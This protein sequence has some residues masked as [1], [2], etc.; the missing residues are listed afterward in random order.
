MSRWRLDGTG[1]ITTL[2]ARGQA[3]DT[4]SP[5]GAE[6]LVA[7]Y[8]SVI[9][10]AAIDGGAAAP[11]TAVWDVERDVLLDPLDGFDGSWVG[12]R[13]L[14]GSFADGTVG[15]YD[16]DSG[17]GVPEIEVPPGDGVWYVPEAERTYEWIV[18]DTD[19]ERQ[20]GVIKT[21]DSSEDGD[22]GGDIAPDIPIVGYVKS[23]SATS[24]GTADRRHRL[25]ARCRQ[26]PQWRIVPHHRVR[27][28]DA[29]W[30]SVSP[31]WGRGPLRSA[32]T[33]RCSAAT[34]CTITEYDL[35]TLQPIGDFPGESGQVSQ[36]QFSSDGRLALVSS[37]DQSL[38][39][40]DVATRNRL[41]DPIPA[42]SPRRVA[43]NTADP[44]GRRWRSRSPTGSRSG[45]W[46]P[47]ASP[48]RRA[49]WS[50]AT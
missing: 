30:R 45:T 9:D 38:S 41:G 20:P 43:G 14:G 24:G 35:D 15:V 8:A 47:T 22:D 5:S 33:A 34:V 7:D 44:T 18:E 21:F 39:V 2:V 31:S 11:D 48:R 23:V 27:R 19:D 46:S 12:P 25:R 28:P 1:P 40:Y 36:I 29:A 50:A 32:P 6:L 42:D 49:S 10:E 26:P 17:S 16:L 3:A 4:Y 13:L 37:N